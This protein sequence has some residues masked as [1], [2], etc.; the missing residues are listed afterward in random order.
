ML[1]SSLRIIPCE[2]LLLI[3]LSVVYLLFSTST[4]AYVTD[5]TTA[6]APSVINRSA[7]SIPLQ[8]LSSGEEIKR[9]TF[10]IYLDEQLVEISVI[11]FCTA[12]DI[13]LGDCK[14]LFRVVSQY[15]PSID[16]QDTSSHNAETDQNKGN[17]QLDSMSDAE[18]ADSDYL[19]LQ[20]KASSLPVLKAGKGVFAKVNISRGSIICEY[21]GAVKTL[22][23]VGN[24]RI[25]DKMM[26]VRGIDAVLY[27]ILG[28]NICAYINDCTSLSKPTYFE[29]LW[30][31]NTGLDVDQPCYDSFSYNAQ[32]SEMSGTT[33]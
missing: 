18:V 4:S 26:M 7:L 23:S 20:V 16:P 5:I 24:R 17:I 10:E 21:R 13:G 2:Q 14:E 19:Y 3:Y 1:R 12:H 29:K 8:Y 11:G 33:Y 30:Y 6:T 32:S 31:L 25:S 15:F 27:V 9:T 22:T 28:N